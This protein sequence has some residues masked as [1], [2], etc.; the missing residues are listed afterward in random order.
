MNVARLW[1]DLCSERS[2]RGTFAD[3]ADGFGFSAA[4]KLSAAGA[5]DQLAGT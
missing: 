3:V 2:R 1:P 5:A 4:V